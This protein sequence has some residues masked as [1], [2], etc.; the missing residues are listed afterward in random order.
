M[1]MPASQGGMGFLALGC[2]VANSIKTNRSRM[3]LVTLHGDGS[4]I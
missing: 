2:H 1:S 3:P 4:M